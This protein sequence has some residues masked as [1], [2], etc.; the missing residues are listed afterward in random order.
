[1]VTCD[2]AGAS[3]NLIAHLDAL[4]SPPGHQLITELTALL[5]EG[6]TGN[7]LAGWPPSMRIFVRRE[8]PHPGA[9]LTLFEAAD[10]WRYILWVT[11]LPERTPGWRGQPAYIDATH[12]VHAR[13]EDA[14][15]ALPCVTCPR[16]MSR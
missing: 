12:R 13:V 5:R 14:K 11:N 8:R 16:D 4:A 3:H 10:G 1:M 9:Q 6:P 7:Q 2:G 15:H